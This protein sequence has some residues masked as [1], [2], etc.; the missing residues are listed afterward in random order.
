[1]KIVLS[2][3]VILENIYAASALYAVT[4]TDKEYPALLCRDQSDA[5]TRV[6][7]DAFSYQLLQMISYVKG[8]SIADGLLNVELSDELASSDF[9]IMPLMQTIVTARTLAAVWRNFD[10]KRS[11]TYDLRASN[12]T[13]IILATAS[14]PS[15]RII[16]SDC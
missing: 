6:I 8:Y 9:S 7:E 1:M 5:L 4:N 13:A 14:F 11:E 12:A 3:D 16:R 2:V 10:L 15:L